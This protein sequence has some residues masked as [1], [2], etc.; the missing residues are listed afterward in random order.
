V[1]SAQSSPLVLDE[2]EASAWWADAELA[3]DI[4]PSA[5][6]AEG[7]S[8]LVTGATGFLGRHVA[9]KLLEREEGDVYC[10]ARSG[11]EGSAHERVEHAVLAAGAPKDAVNSRLYVLDADL[12]QS[13]LG[14]SENEYDSLAHSVAAIV[15]CAADVSWVRSYSRL[16]ASNVLPVTALLRLACHGQSKHFALISSLGVC[17]STNP[18]V[19]MAEDSDPL[20]HVSTMPLGYAQSK[21]VAERLV[22]QGVHRGLDASIFRPA[23]ISGDSGGRHANAEDFVSMLLNGCIRLGYAPDSEWQLD[24]VPVDFASEAIVTNLG[25]HAGLSTLHLAHPEPRE[26]REL[27]LFLNLYGYTIRLEPFSDWR[28][29]LKQHPDVALPLKR[30]LGFFAKPARGSTGQ[31]VSQVY[32]ASGRVRISSARS[33]ARLAAQHLHYPRLSAAYFARYLTALR[34][35]GALERPRR[36]RSECEHRGHFETESLSA[37]RPYDPTWRPASFES[38]G[39]IVTEI[40]SWRYG[41]DLGLYGVA[42]GDSGTDHASLILKIKARDEEAIAT[43][44][45]VATI[46]H[47]LLGH[48]MGRF[49]DQLP[50][51]GADARETSFYAAAPSGLLEL[52]PR[53]HA[54][55]R[56]PDTGRAMLLLERLENVE[57]LNSI[58]Q[59]HH[60]TDRHLRIA[61]R[62]LAKIHALGYGDATPEHSSI[63]GLEQLN[64]DGILQALP[65]HEALVQTGEP[66]FQKWGGPEL[67]AHV[68]K[69][70]AD[71]GMWMPA[72]ARQPRTL[73]HNDCNPRNMAFR[74]VDGN[75][76][77]CWYDWELCAWA[78]PQRDLAE[79]L[80]FTLD[81]NAA[82]E[83][84]HNYIELHRRELSLQSG[85]DIEM[86]SWITGFRLA[87]AELMVR[88]LTLYTLLHS[89]VRQSFLPRVV[90]TWQAIEHGLSS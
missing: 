58:D 48:L 59:P 80:C 10:L 34:R 56:H 72:Y 23:L 7:H 83:R 51:V 6:V 36:E 63:R 29:R 85:C 3:A 84:V 13:R 22:R 12:A 90:R 53:C 1:T 54:Q 74:R 61:I 5:R 26:W 11:K 27:V 79:L 16:R 81:V 44:I 87:L 65:L 20:T 64:S 15:H 31:S 55:G 57:L 28:R 52:A 30:L 76:R 82:P 50:L 60:W 18:H 69:L 49:S 35:T 62:D 47:P 77:T 41:G 8:V 32:E 43:A 67:V 14:I 2:A 88:R 9:R 42:R 21:A 40:A 37:L 25:R 24:V 19:R 71:I 66:F 38:H 78:P 46:T 33:D 89:S 73:I 86:R 39:S 75:L 17:Y 68:G 4:V 70:I 45:E